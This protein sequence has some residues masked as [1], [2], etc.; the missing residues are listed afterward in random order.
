M[1]KLLLIVVATFFVSNLF[2]QD[3]QK[4]IFGIKAGANYST[5][6]ISGIELG[7]TVGVNGG[8]S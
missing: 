5:F 3:L 6:E 8:L 1:K 2:A 7:Y 4:N